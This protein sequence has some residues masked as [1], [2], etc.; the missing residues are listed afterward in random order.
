M[1]FQVDSLSVD[2][3]HCT[4]GEGDPL[5]AAVKVAVPFPRTVWLV[6]CVVIVGKVAVVTVSIAGSVLAE[7][8]PLV[9]TARNSKPLSERGTLVTLKVTDV[10]PA[11]SLQ[12]DPPS[13]D[14]CHCSL[15]NC[16][17]I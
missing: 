7:P 11:M 6:G 5:A 13:V 10:A 12:V 8:A 17:P 2:S 14:C 4:V 3:C 1:S 15:G 9:N 16:L